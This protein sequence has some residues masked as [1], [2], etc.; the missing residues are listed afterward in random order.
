[1]NNLDFYVQH[2]YL[3]NSKLNSSTIIKNPE[4]YIG[5]NEDPF[6]SFNDYIKDTTKSWEKK[7]TLLIL[8]VMEV[9]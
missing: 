4:W 1:M 3:L 7:K 6:L 2:H 9:F 8:V 5:K